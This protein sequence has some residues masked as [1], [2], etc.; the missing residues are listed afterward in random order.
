MKSV[1]LY[2]RYLGVDADPRSFK[3]K[4]R[5]GV[6]TWSQHRSAIVRIWVTAWSRPKDVDLIA[7]EDTRNIGLLLAIFEITTP[8]TSFHEHNAMEKFQIWSAHLESERPA[9]VPMQDFLVFLT[10]VMIC[11]DWTRDSSWA[12]PG[13]SAG[14]TGVWLASGFAALNSYFLWISAFAQATE[15]LF[16]RKSGPSGAPRSFM[17]LPSSEGNLRECWLSMGIVLMYCLW[18]DKDLRGIY[19]AAVFELVSTFLKKI[20]SQR[21]FLDRRRS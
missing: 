15:G 21:E 6:L 12:V 19:F 11:R 17:S 2:E 13:P 20:L 18:I 8:Q 10:L 14:I 3:G 16:S 7:A 4:K 9:Q 1:C 5:T